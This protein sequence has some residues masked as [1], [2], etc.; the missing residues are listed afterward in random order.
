[1]YSVNI[2]EGENSNTELFFKDTAELLSYVKK[3]EQTIKQMDFGIIQKKK[4]LVVKKH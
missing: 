3:N 1:M 4:V 2:I